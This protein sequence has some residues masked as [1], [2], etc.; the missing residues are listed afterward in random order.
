LFYLGSTYKLTI[1]NNLGDNDPNDQ[2]LL[3]SQCSTSQSSHEESERDTSSI[4]IN[5]SSG[6]PISILIFMYIVLK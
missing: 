4:N 6:I 3:S 5:V 1:L 2:V